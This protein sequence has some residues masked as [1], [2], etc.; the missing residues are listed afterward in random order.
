M[1]ESKE[2]LSYAEKRSFP[3]FR[4]EDGFIRSSE[5]GAEHTTPLALV[6]DKT[7]IYFN[8]NQPSDLENILNDSDFDADAVLMQQAKALLQVL[9]LLKVSKYNLGSL[10]PAHEILGPKYKKRVLVL[11]QVELDAGVRYGMAGDW[12]SASLIRLARSENPQAEILYRPH[13]EVIR[14]FREN[15]TDLEEL[16][17]ICR[18]ITEDIAVNELFQHVDRVY[19]ISSLS[20]FE[21][22][23][24]GIPVTVVGAPFYAGWGLTDDRAL[25]PRRRRVLTLE[26]LFC[27]AYLLYPRYLTNPSDPVRGA[28]AAILCV[29]AQRRARLNALLT[30][31][32]AIDN[33]AIVAAS[34]YWPRLLMKDVLP[35]LIKSKPK[36]IASLLQP[37]KFLNRCGGEHYR[38]AVSCILAGK[39]RGTAS[40]PALL[41]ALRSAVSAEQFSDLLTQLWNLQPSGEL[42]H[43]WAWHCERHGMSQDAE[44]AFAFAA[45]GLRLP[46]ASV[47]PVSEAQYP[48]VLRLAQFHL[49]RR[50][51]D[52]AWDVL[53][54]L[55]LS[56]FVNVETLNAI[57]EIAKLRF[58][59]QSATAVLD[60]LNRIQPDWK[61]GRGYISHSNT[62]SLS[63]DVA[64]AISSVAYA[65]LINPQ[66]VESAYYVEQQ[67]ERTF[68]DL[69]LSSALH[70]AVEVLD[71]QPSSISRARALIFGRRLKDAEKLLLEYK[72]KASELLQYGLALSS[73]YSQQGKLTEAKELIVSLTSSSPSEALYREGLRLAVLMNDYEWGEYLIAEAERRGF[74]V[75]DMYQ[76]KIGFGRR[77]IK[78]SYL[79]FRGSKTAQ[80]LRT[81]LGEKYVQDLAS[82]SRGS[83]AKV[84][85]LAYFGPGDEIRFAAFYEELRRRLVGPDLLITCDPRLHALL[86]RSFPLIQFVPVE[87][88]RNL[89]ASNNAQNFKMLPGSDLHAVADNAGWAL[90][91]ECDL[92]TLSTDPLGDLIDGYESFSGNPYL[93]PDP[94]KVKYWKSRLEGFKAKRIVGLSWRSSLATHARNEHYV[95]VEHLVPLLQLEDVQFVNLQYDDCATEL[96]WIEERFPGKM[97]NPEGLDQ[98][99]DL[100]NVAALMHCL[101][102]IVS[103][104]TTVIELAGSLGCPALLL[105][106][107]SELHWRKLPG[108]DVDVWHRSVRH[109]EGEFLGNKDSL[110]EAARLAL[111]GGLENEAARATVDEDEVAQDFRVLN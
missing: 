23:I 91:N 36:E 74:S 68:G 3:L 48:H 57:A 45:S 85:V 22:L 70:D 104:A 31:A 14:K 10:A 102:L 27:G 11:G 43:H 30:P 93:I 49:R 47:A 107:S 8:A 89:H 109:I 101:D 39:L 108:S 80:L 32:F 5:L 37:Q 96:A 26:Q 28:L 21:A 46:E 13:P 94:Q 106:N 40:F 103:P 105:S 69:P 25:V 82:L 83:P 75:G 44:K 38:H 15:S 90:V 87:R 100:D 35:R 56:G 19:T 78:R 24:H 84:A 50:A 88:L 65:C 6:L 62:A 18:V 73:A 86:Q 7:G 98:Y 66:S 110:M 41:V 59:F 81:Y 1:T 58:D 95:F 34:E 53:Q 63:G 77:E 97:W 64:A 42:L 111:Q 9:R 79:S 4:M 33:A 72:P 2:L 20:G 12:D 55:L 29:T 17:K 67:V 16:K 54:R 76:R 52:K 92:V 61:L 60:M 99:N 71:V 51:L